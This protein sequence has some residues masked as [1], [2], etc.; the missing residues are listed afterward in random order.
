[1]RF[2]LLA[3][4]CLAF[5]SAAQAQNSIIERV[6]PPNWWTGMVYNEVQLIVYG[7]NVG[8]TTEVQIKYPGVRL[9]NVEH[10]ENQ[11]YLFLTLEIKP[12]A[13][14]GDVIIHFEMDG[15]ATTHTFPI[16]ERIERP[17]SH[18]GFDATDVVYLLMPDRFANGDTSNDELEGMEEK[19]DRDDIYGRHGGDIAGIRQHLDYIKQ[20]GVT[21]LWLNPVQENNMPVESYHG[22]AI[23]DFYHVDARFGGN[24]AYI[25]MVN[26]AH[27]LGLKVIM[28]MIVNH[29]GTNNWFIKDLP[30]TDWI[31]QHDEFTR[32]NYRGVMNNDPYV[33]KSDLAK[34]NKGWFDHTM[35]DLNQQNPLLARYLIQ[36]TLWWIEYAGLDG[37]RMDT[38][39]YPDKYFLREWA[40]TV[41][42]EYPNFNIVGEVWENKSATQS[43]WLKDFNSGID[44][45]T[46]FVFNEA[47]NRAFTEEKGWHTGLSRIYYTLT[48][49]R[50]YPDANNLLTF[51][52]NHDLPRFYSAVNED[53]RKL[54]M[55][56]AVLLTMRG[57]PQIYYGTEVAL[58]GHSHGEVRPEFF[59]GWKDHTKSAFTGNGLDV[60]EAGM[61]DYTR[62]L[63]HWRQDSKV[64]HSGKLMHFVPE[65]EIYVYFRY[66]A[67]ACIM[68]LLNANEEAV[69]VGTDRFKERMNGYSSGTDIMNGK[70]VPDLNSI[71][72]PPVSALII[73]LHP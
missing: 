72:V 4:F 26:E 68:V 58:S 8:S 57:I 14:A 61:L 3:I 7:Q 12:R 43:Y 30:Q 54:K 50:I 55:G 18:Q 49:D 46:D 37:I 15:S 59:G 69:D 40:E 5:S 51:L 19:L 29:A 44:C 23:T 6:E 66:D 73:E 9:K 53:V 28:D 2:F 27:D 11:N 13:K 65:E 39:S 25:K 35:A 41:F 63:L 10:V 33:A 38:W 62:K 20:L 71:R 60:E 1:M 36:Q 45:I 34:M 70:A 22:Y 67:D 42:R 21:A 48:E 31:H 17:F 52:D 16:E 24:P 56:L 64:I 32:S 47:L